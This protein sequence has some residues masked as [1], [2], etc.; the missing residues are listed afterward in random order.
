MAFLHAYFLKRH[1]RT[2][3]SAIL[4]KKKV[5]TSYY[6]TAWNISLMNGSAQMNDKISWCW[7]KPRW[8]KEFGLDKAIIPDKALHSPQFPDILQDHQRPD[9][10]YSVAVD[11]RRD[12]LRI[13]YERQLVNLNIA[14]KFNMCFVKFSNDIIHKIIR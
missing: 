3:T 5:L 11:L 4:R 14:F 7:K 1:Q 8:W 13:Y 10:N 2:A 9:F 6:Y 12:G